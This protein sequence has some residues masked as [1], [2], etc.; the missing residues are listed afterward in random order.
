MVDSQRDGLSTQ[1][2][3]E[4]KIESSDASDLQQA[5]NKEAQPI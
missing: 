4:A 1:T 5:A 2:R 3:D